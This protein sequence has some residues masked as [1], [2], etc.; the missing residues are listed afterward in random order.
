MIQQRPPFSP[1][2]WGRDGKPRSR[3]A[4]RNGRPSSLSDGCPAAPPLLQHWLDEAYVLAEDWYLLSP[5]IRAEASALT[6]PEPLTQW[7]VAHNLLTEYQAARL[8]AGTTL[9]LVLGSYRVLNRLGAGGMG[10]VFLAEHIRMRRQVA[11]KV[12]PMHF[13][14]DQRLLHRFLTEMR[15]VAQ[16]QHPNIVYAIDAGEC[17]APDNSDTILHYFVMEYVPGTDLDDLVQTQGPLTLAKTADLTYQIASALAEANKHHLV[18]RDIKPSNIQ[19]TPEG[20]A[21]LLDFGL[22]R[23]LGHQLTEPGVLLGTLDYIAPEQIRDAHNVDIRA[24]LYGLGGVIFWCLTGA[25]PFPSVNN[26]FD[27]GNRFQQAPPSLRDQRP[28]L[29][30]AFD[31]IV[32]RLL[33]VQPEDRFQTP[34]QLMSAL[35]PFLREQGQDLLM[36]TPP[37]TTSPTVCLDGS[38]GGAPQRILIVDDEP[39]IRTLCR[40]VLQAEGMCCDECG[41]GDQA[42]T[43]VR[44]QPYDLILCDVNMKEMPGTELCRRLREDPA[45]PNLKLVMMSGG[46]NADIMAQMLLAGADDF[47]TKPFSVIQL[48]ARVKAALRLKE[49]QDR[50]DLLNRHLQKINEQLERNLGDRAQALVAA[51]NAMI[52]AL[53]RLVDHRVGDDGGRLYRMQRYV[54]A[55]AEE[56]A[57]TS[58]FAGHIDGAFIELLEA[59]APLHD[60]GKIA[61]PDHILL[62]P[63]RLETEERLQM[64][65]HTIIGAETMQTIAKKHGFELPFLQMATEVIRHHHE[66]YDGNGYPDRLAGDN[67]PLAARIVAI[68]DVYDALRTRRTYKPALSHNAAMQVM[69]HG[70][71][72]HFDP[73]LLHVF[74][75]LGDVFARIYRESQQEMAAA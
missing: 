45:G 52:L 37:T 61:L 21:K 74:E 47:I 50:G 65:T 34:Q 56:A 18:H 30:L 66:R 3:S 16:L 23:S 26:V 69:L 40:A 46:V 49:A 70:S 10:V 51:R 12:L 58:H 71:P 14:Q 63:T 6:E 25:P 5:E 38:R 7:L 15:T 53:A 17:A 48:K 55:L 4:G 59:C 54:R 28:E 31:T 60:I 41:D 2:S 62:K 64:Q 43:M 44:Q 72:G 11:I 68:A 36:P 33:A 19:V 20:Q 13:D 67:I 9:G 42:L 1:L 75:R 22:A 57:R 32:R 24:D 35:M 73:A 27:V 8:L 39:A 29:P